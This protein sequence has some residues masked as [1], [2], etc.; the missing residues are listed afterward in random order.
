MAT[1]KAAS[2]TLYLDTLSAQREVEVLTSKIQRLDKSIADGQAQGKKMTREL[3]SLEQAKTALTKVQDQIDRGLKPSLKQLEDLARKTN[4]ELKRLSQSDPEFQK[5]VQIYK[6]AQSQIRTL[7]AEISG[8]SQAQGQWLSQIKQFGGGLLTGFIAGFGIQTITSL[9]GES[10]QEFTE[11][12]LASA[13]FEAKLRNLGRL[14]VFERLTNEANKLAEQFKFLDND[15]IT[16]VFSKLIDYG[17]LT[18]TQ[19]KQLTPVI[20]DFA[21]NQR[22]SLEE[23][24]SVIIKALEGNGKAL[25]EYGID[26]KDAKDETEAF[27][28]IMDQVKPKVEGAAEVFGNTLAGS[29][30]TAQQEIANLKEEIGENLQPVIKGF[31]KALADFSSTLKETISSDVGFFTKT[32]ALLGNQTAQA[33]VFASNFLAK[34]KEKSTAELLNSNSLML[35][36]SPMTAL[37]GN[38]TKIGSG[39]EDEKNTKKTTTTKIADNPR[40]KLL[41]ELKQ[42]ED[43]IALLGKTNDEKELLRINNK[44]AKLITEAKKYSDIVIRLEAARNKEVAN[45]VEQIT[46]KQEEERKKQEAIEKQKTLTIQNENLKR[47]EAEF[48]IVADSAKKDALARKSLAILQAETPEARLKAE[49][50]FL[51]L[52]KNLALEAE[53]LT[54]AE[55]LVINQQYYNDLQNLDDEYNRFI[56]ERTLA[57]ITESLNITQ[58][59]IGAIDQLFQIQ[60]NRENARLKKELSQN[61]QRRASFKRLLDQRLISEAEYNRRVQALNEEDDKKKKELQ[62]KQFNRQKATQIAQAYI[63]GALAAI[64]AVSNTTLPFPASLIGPAIIAAGTAIQIAAI[65]SQKPPEYAKGGIAK[66]GRHSEGGIDLYDRKSKRVVGNIEGGEPIMVLSRNT[67]ANNGDIVDA[68]LDSS[69]NRGGARVRRVWDNRNYQSFNYSAATRALSKRYFETG[70]VIAAG[71]GAVINEDAGNNAAVADLM[72][73]VMHTLV[74]VAE[75]NAALRAE[76]AK[77]IEANVSLKKF[78]DAETL[79]GQIKADGTM[80]P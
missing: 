38:D 76:L 11:A 16:N 49:K 51:E 20:I 56:Q 71:G 43:E 72:N 18:E 48:K 66:G 80:K 52:K 47:R 35:L 23:S 64:Q 68:L 8:V 17:K 57:R 5:K 21:A 29:A 74:M 45:L 54:A 36:A 31:Y 67:Y 33:K 73:N 63:S 69:M 61:D 14:D 12:E 39:N 25:K 59:L 53:G 41:R 24:A 78:R 40:F 79:D 4:F 6:D 55:K 30:A 44:Y 70:G 75:T 34:D 7:K 13:R 19:I 28:I 60:S 65:A 1:P 26:I 37:I 62:R 10:V 42:L 58:E 27:G 22:I 2:R 3:A 77:G 15:D 50:D 9:I 46:K 32:L